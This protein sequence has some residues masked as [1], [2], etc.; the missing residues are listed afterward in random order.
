MTTHRFVLTAA[1][2]I[3]SSGVMPKPCTAD[4]AE[5]TNPHPRKVAS[6]D[7]YVMLFQG[8]SGTKRYKATGHHVVALRVEVDQRFSVF[9]R[10][11]YHPVLEGVITA[12]DEK[13]HA[14]VKAN[15]N[16]STGEFVGLIEEDAPF[17][18]RGYLGSSVILPFYF[19]VT[20]NP[21]SH[22]KKKGEASTGGEGIG[23]RSIDR[24]KKQM[25]SW[26]NTRS[27]VFCDGERTPSTVHAKKAVYDVEVREGVFTTIPVTA[28]VIP[29]TGKIWMGPEQEYYI[30]TDSGIVGFHMRLGGTI[31]WCKSLAKEPARTVKTQ[32]EKNDP[33]KGFE[34]TVSGFSLFDAQIGADREAR[35]ERKTNLNQI[36]SHWFFS[37][38]V[39]S[40]QS[41][42][43]RILRAELS[44]GL[45][46][47]DLAN[48]TGEYKASV[49][50]DVKS[51]KAIKADEDKDQYRSPRK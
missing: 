43:A 30:E 19:I 38:G 3:A 8:V 12:K 27:A 48:P 42:L 25:T 13:L 35:R 5:A 24:K 44:G 16:V 21:M 49:W 32:S 29:E 47:L 11:G 51:R 14:K 20:K 31:F 15:L 10:D 28:F 2:L 37:E 39:A 9:L 34:R 22:L 6:D 4:S 50:I 40:S 23:K 7:L 41:G 36:I 33:S 17:A 46:K 45:L 18:P 26:G 1:F